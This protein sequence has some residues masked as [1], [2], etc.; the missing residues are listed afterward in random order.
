MGTHCPMKPS[1]GRAGSAHWAGHGDT[2][3]LGWSE[4]ER[5]LH[6]SCAATN[7]WIISSCAAVSWM[8][9]PSPEPWPPASEVPGE[10]TGRAEL[11]DAGSVW[12][13]CCC[14]CF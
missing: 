2:V 6:C 3:T 5:L 1:L 9:S 7:C 14:C 12:D 10:A 11:L 13:G 8:P 4:K